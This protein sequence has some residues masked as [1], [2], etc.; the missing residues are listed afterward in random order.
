MGLR[1]LSFLARLRVSKITDYD[2]PKRKSEKDMSV[3]QE[4]KCFIID[5]PTELLA[6]ISAQLD[7]LS[8]ACLALTCRRLLLISGASLASEC[9]GFKKDFAP[10]F[11]HYRSS[12]SFA[13]ER[14]K[15]V[16]RLEDGKWLACS[17][18]LKLHPRTA[19]PPKELRRSP[20]TRMCNLGESAGLVDLCPCVKLTFQDKANLVKHLRQRE[21]LTRLPS[22]IFGSRGYDE[23]YLWHSCTASYG[24]TDLKIGIYPELR[25]DGKLYI[26]TEYRMEMEPNMLG[27]EKHISPRF[28]C[29]HRSMDLWLYSVSQTLYCH[30]YDTFCSACKQI[31]GCSRCDTTLKTPQRRPHHC[32]ETNKV[33]YF[34]WTQR[35]LGSSTD[36]PDKEFAAQRIH[37]VDPYVTWKNCRELCPWTARLHPPPNQ[38]PALGNEILEPALVDNNFCLHGRLDGISVINGA[39]SHAC[40]LTKPNSKAMSYPPPFSNDNGLHPYPSQYLQQIPQNAAHSRAPA[41]IPQS[42]PQYNVGA[43]V[44]YMNYTTN[45]FAYPQPLAPSYAPAYGGQHSPPQSLPHQRGLAPTLPQSPQQQQHLYHQ[46]R[47][48]QF[49]SPV[50]QQHPHQ[51]HP[52]SKSSPQQNQALQRQ[53]QQYGSPIIQ[54]TQPPHRSLSYP[55]PQAAHHPSPQQNQPQLQP[56]VQVQQRQQQYTP[57]MVQQHQLLPQQSHQPTSQPRQQQAQ[58]QVQQPPTPQQGPP[59]QFVNPS[60]T[61]TEPVRRL[62]IHD[63]AASASPL[64][65][66][67][68]GPPLTAPVTPQYGTLPAVAPPASVVSNHSSYPTASNQLPSSHE[69]HTHRPVALVMPPKNEKTDTPSRPANQSRKSSTQLASPFSR[70][71]QVVIPSLSSIQKMSAPKASNQSPMAA[72]QTIKT[73]P[74]TR[75]DND[76]D[77]QT[78]LLALADEYLNAAHSK[79]TILALSKN[80]VDLKEYY[81]LVATGLG[82]LEAALSVRTPKQFVRQAL[83]RLRYARIL[84]EETD[85][86]VAAETALS[87]GIELCERNKLLDLKYT[88]QQ[89]LARMLHK[90]NPKA[91]AKAV[92]N[93]I[94]DVETY[95]HTHWEYAFRLLRVSLALSSASHQDFVVAINNLQKLSNLASR[96]GDKL[97]SVIAALIEALAHL[98]QSTSADSVEQAQ[99]AVALAR[100]HQLD[101]RVQEIPQ[102]GSMLQMVDIS[103]SLL[104][105]DLT[106]ASQKLQVMQ[107]MMDQRINDSRW[108]DDGSFSIPLNA[109]PP[110][111]LAEMG[112]ILSVEDGQLCLTLQWLPQHDLYSLCYLL[113]S[114]TLGAKNSHDG[115]KAEKYLQEGL[116]MLRGS[117][118]EPEENTE[119]LV[120]AGERLEWRRVLH[121]NILLHLTFLAC[122]RTDWEAASQT[123]RDLKGAVKELDNAL[124]ETISCLMQYATGVIAQGTGDLA[125]ALTA[126]DSPILSLTSSMNKTMRNDPRRDTAILA[127]LNK[128][129]IIREP[130]HPSH[131][132]LDQVLS[133]VEP[134]CLGSSNKYIQA[135]YYLICATVHNESTIQTKQYLQQA[136]HSA[137]AISNSQITCM[138][139]TFMSWKYFRGVVGEQ[140]EKSARA[141]RAMAKKANDRLWVSVTDQMLAETLER[142]GKADEA[143]VVREE[144]DRLLMGLPTALKRTECR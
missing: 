130:A 87:K 28:G 108:R 115:R 120:A 11:H 1:S 72:S 33:S 104:E 75:F 90:S 39:L 34:F 81:K 2:D 36:I 79:G 16:E 62:P 144:A 93:M 41:P 140:S 126:F 60:D 123:L 44:Q 80:E 142:Q 128:I 131:S 74:K 132:R 30:R 4:A 134:H 6:L 52:M 105:Y 124:P 96:S 14:W 129:L 101:P 32:P 110:P 48:Q 24:S 8:E 78:L 53:Q 125:A 51:H 94:Q 46:Q 97:V 15:L 73:P 38:A 77:Y 143:R 43:N 95:R 22:S 82:C 135:A 42:Q 100:S 139:L 70:T 12:Q 119:S 55:S 85:N 5:L 109:Q 68:I 40:I 26:R 99:H 84:I 37:P 113:S 20:T 89:L 114:A 64:L 59:I 141:G 7:P 13:T 137:T 107:S 17:Q 10:L 35:C 117:F 69:Q 133:V 136:L 27:K 21:L 45:S 58:Q 3:D 92:D 57:P 91:A 98:Q 47:Q 112:D 103:C 127:G 9:L 71:P 19:F 116:R 18:C 76:V 122:A 121:C 86:D 66:Y 118:K 138:T 88:M 61:F 25:D 102:I 67:Q 111:K 83:T 49:G 63:V 29:A 54:Q 56:Q 31:S 106:Q 50:T 23:R 65:P